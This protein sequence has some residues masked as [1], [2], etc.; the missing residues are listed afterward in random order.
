MA[1]YF[2][3][4]EKGLQLEVQPI[5]EIGAYDFP[6]LSDEEKAR[7]QRLRSIVRDV[8]KIERNQSVAQDDGELERFYRRELNPEQCE[9]AFALS[10]P[11]LVIAGA[12][13][14]K[15]RTIVYRT[16]YMLQKGIPPESILL[17]TFTRRAAGEMIERVKA[18]VGSDTASRIT[19]GTFHSF[20]NLQLRRYGREIGV[21]PNFT[22]C[23]EE[24]S[25][26]IVELIKSELD[27]KS[28]GKQFPKKSVVVEMISR[29]RNHGITIE[30]AVSLH[31][32]KYADS[33]PELE[34]IA[35]RYGI[36]KGERGMLDYDDLLDKFLELLEKSPQTLERL[37]NR[38]SY[39]MVDEY[40][41]TN[42][43][44]GRIADKIA[45]AS[46]NIMVV[47]DDSQSIYAFRGANFENILRFPERWKDCRLIKLVRNYRSQCL[48]L[49]FTNDIVRNFYVSYDKKLFSEMRDS[50]LKPKIFRAGSQ[51]QEAELVVSK[52][53]ELIDRKGVEPK[54]IAVLYRSSFHANAL[55]TVLLRRGID[56]AMFG[57]VKFTERRHVK[58][59][60]S[61]LR[62]IQNPKEAVALNRVVRL[63]PGVG[64][65]TAAKIAN[66]FTESG[67]L[68]L[69]KYAKKKFYQPLC[70]LSELLDEASKEELSTRQLIDIVIDFYKPILKELEEDYDERIEDFAVL[71][72]VA[73][74][75]RTLESFLTDFSLDPP[76]SQLNGS[77]IDIRD[78][79]KSDKVVLSTI[80]SAKG[81]E[82]NTVFV[83]NMAEGAFPSE[84]SAGN[85]SMLEEERR[86]FYVA[87][88]RAKERLFISYPEKL[89]FCQGFGLAMP[90]RF[91]AEIDEAL[92]DFGR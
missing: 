92:Y 75:Y 47:G 25:A 68:P 39:V 76:N 62:I 45:A 79:S 86:L 15:T 66:E 84:K 64:A 4:E 65:S 42:L 46:G 49:D 69:E 22:I 27:I 74:G 5:P 3:S 16:A 57:G 11:T 78:A 50:T 52:I 28:L 2:Y 34:K 80:H 63:L 56:F 88:S 91:L 54:D 87:C 9:A 89:A 37:Q 51:E 90:S 41:D 35:E 32:P 81:L 8:E 85:L 19:A 1:R 31:Y 83:I 53:E 58:D 14:G 36:F 20:A 40:Q 17:L 23:D 82:W 59:L 13:S 73:A 55:Q 12:G 18:L 24:D 7:Y 29:A 6:S 67:R 48:L 10:G 60:L 30:K 44:Q 77:K 26:D 33:I 21:E 38:Y 70:E 71:R 43:V 72:T 61:Y